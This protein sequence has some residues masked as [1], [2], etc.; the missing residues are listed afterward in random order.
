MTRSDLRP[1]GRL[2][3]AFAT[4][5]R[6][7]P[8]N[9]AAAVR[10]R[11]DLDAQALLAA[12]ERVAK[13]NSALRQVL[14]ED[15]KYWTDGGRLPELHLADCDEH[16]LIERG[17]AHRFQPGSALWSVSAIGEPEA[18]TAT[19]VVVA[20]HLLMDGPS[21]LAV[22]HA[23]G[24]ELAG[25]AS[26]RFL[27]PLKLESR[28]SGGGLRPIVSA[29]TSAMRQEWHYRRGRRHELEF[30]RSDCGHVI[31]YGLDRRTAAAVSRA[32]RKHRLTLHSVLQGAHAL[33]IGAHFDEGDLLRGVAFADLRGSIT[34]PAPPVELGAAVTMMPYVAPARGN[35]LDVSRR[36]Q[37]VLTRCQR[38]GTHYGRIWL[39]P[40]MMTMVERGGQRMADFALSWSGRLPQWNRGDIRIDRIRAFV[41][42]T[43][44]GPI[45][46][47]WG[48]RD[49]NGIHCNASWPAE[50]WSAESAAVIA[51]SVVRQL[52]SLPDE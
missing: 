49:E 52:Q 1:L 4:T 14:T 22:Y 47:V 12:T 8:F 18:R 37:S 2:E 48:H 44:V 35:L 19:L 13:K 31:N 5:D 46:G 41:S 25:E 15:R 10:Y 43:R 24:D 16:T 26:Q 23:V 40:L 32:A 51:H 36:I 11:G 9:I 50:C 45:W 33:A 20:N 6:I 38:D 34:P 3:R 27:P 28:W 29:M 17:L 42:P 7:S 39:S 30:H 21:L